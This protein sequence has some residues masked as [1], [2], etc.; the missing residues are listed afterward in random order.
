ME[1]E[2]KARLDA[3]QVRDLRGRPGGRGGGAKVAAGGGGLGL[4]GLVVVLLLQML[5]GGGAGGID[6]GG[7]LS[8]P[9]IENLDGAQVGG[10]GATGGPAAECRTGADANERADCRI[11]AVVNSVQ[12]FW[13]RELERSGL[14]Y[15][16]SVTTFFTGRVS[17]ACGAASSA[18]GPFYCPADRGVYIDLAFYEE[19]RTRFRASGGPFAEAYVIAHEYGHHVQNLLGVSER[20]QR[21]GDRAGPESALVRLELQADCYAGVWAHHAEADGFIKRLTDADVRDG[22]DA[23]EKVG[24]DY[25]QREFQGRI[26]REAWTHGSSAQRQRWF[27]TGWRSGDPAACDTFSGR[28]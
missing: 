24:D 7:A 8:L 6:L 3:S 23:A 28:I 18:V 20:V 9:G 11:V 5:G 26:D 27:T 22:L 25:V 17:T 12:Q 14:R 4:V 15:E 16:P 2:E 13:E 1:F 21:S 10:G 19:F